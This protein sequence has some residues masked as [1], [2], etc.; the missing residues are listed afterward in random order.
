MLD[1]A[2]RP[3]SRRTG[4]GLAL[5]QSGFVAL[6][7]RGHTHVGLEVDSENETGATRLYERAGMKVTRRYATYE[8]VLA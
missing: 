8:K 6:W 5:L 7:R 1:L 3:A 4:L 2:V